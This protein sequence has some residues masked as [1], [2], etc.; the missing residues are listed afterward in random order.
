MNGGDSITNCEQ[1]R[2]G[3]NLIPNMALMIGTYIGFR[4]LETLAKP[5]SG[6][7]NVGAAIAVKVLAV[8]A[9]LVSGF[10]CVSTLL[11]G[12]SIPK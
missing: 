2:T 4:M 6:Y 12:A 8:L 5:N 10:A 11:G 9:F 1:F 7:G 3:G